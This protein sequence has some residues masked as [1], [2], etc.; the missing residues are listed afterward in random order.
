MDTEIRRHLALEP[1][2][3]LARPRVLQVRIELRAPDAA[4]RAGG[5]RPLLPVLP[6]AVF[7]GVRPGVPAPPVRGI[8]I[9]ERVNRRRSWVPPYNGLA[10]TTV[11]PLRQVVVKPPRRGHVPGDQVVDLAGS[12]LRRIE[13]PTGNQSA[14]AADR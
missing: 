7:V 10:F 13:C 11:L 5:R 14:P 4:V 12:R 2:G 8:R 6:D 1:E 3:G 9:D